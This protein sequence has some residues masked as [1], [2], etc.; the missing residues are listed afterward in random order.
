MTNH[1][2]RERAERPK[3]SPTVAPKNK[4]AAPKASLYE[5]ITAR[6]IADLEAAPSLGRSLGALARG[7]PRSDCRETPQPGNPIPASMC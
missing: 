6:I 2:H 1:L 3:E 7:T 5:E 4:T